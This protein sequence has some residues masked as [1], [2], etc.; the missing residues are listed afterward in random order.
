M[1][2]TVGLL[3]WGGHACTG[4]PTTRPPKLDWCGFSLGYKKAL[5]LCCTYWHTT[6]RESVLLLKWHILIMSLY[7][8]M[9]KCVHVVYSNV[10][11]L[12]HAVNSTAVLHC[13]L[14]QVI[15]VCVL[16]ILLGQLIICEWS[17]DQTISSIDRCLVKCGHARMCTVPVYYFK[18]VLML[19]HIPLFGL[20]VSEG[21]LNSKALSELYIT[22]QS[23]HI[24]HL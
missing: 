15:D 5:P 8:G 2:V 14:Y 13:M 22:R 19:M 1:V 7:T 9:L 10:P 24:D 17:E 12:L 23:L 20:T 11:L 18:A 21:L 4:S 16:R 3:R 6:W